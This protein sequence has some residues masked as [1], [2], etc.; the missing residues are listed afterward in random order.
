VDDVT[1]RRSALAGLAPTIRPG[2]AGGLEL[3][4]HAGSAIL[5][6]E[7]ARQ[8]QCL[9]AA[10]ERLQLAELPASGRSGGRDGGR[11]LSIGPSIWLFVGEPPVPLTFLDQAFDVAL[12][13]S[14]GW[15][16]LVVSGRR[17]TE[18]LAK[19]CALDFHP[20]RFPPGSCAATGFARM[21]VIVWRSLDARFDLFV[22]RSYA[23]SLWD[24]LAEAAL[25]FGFHGDKN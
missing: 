8:G 2:D 11:L 5:H 24:W 23:L 18:L 20:S 12:D 14:D 6:L 13:V 22:G 4:E 1:E 16:R 19:G 3:Y 25:E 9:A 17:S 10:L 21:R 15:T 7:G